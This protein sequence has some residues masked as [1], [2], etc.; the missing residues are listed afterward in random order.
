[1]SDFYERISGMSQKRLMLLAMELQEKLE[2]AEAEKNPPTNR[3][4]LDGDWPNLAI[5]TAP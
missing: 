2:A 1:M 3:G 5:T 4:P